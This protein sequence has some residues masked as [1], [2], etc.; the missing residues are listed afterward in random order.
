MTNAPS[1]AATAADRW[2]AWVG[3]SE[4]RRDRIT[5]APLAALAAALDR[6]DAPVAAGDALPPLAHWLYFLA[7]PRTCDLGPDGH[8]RRGGFLPPLP[9]PR[10]MWAGSRVRFHD[11]LVVGDDATCVSRI[12]GVDA[13][14]G[15]SGALVF[16]RV[17]H[18][19]STARGLA[20]ADEHDI[21]YRDAAPRDAARGG[22]TGSAAS[23][24]AP[25]EAAPADTAAASA[26]PAGSAGA[27]LRPVDHGGPA[28]ADAAASAAAAAPAPVVSP[29]P[30]F[31]RRVEPDAVLLF[32]YSALTFN[33]HRI[34]YDR[35]YAV[36]V[37]GYPGLV[38]HGPLLAT[39][40]VN[41]ARD[42]APGRRL[43]AFEFKALRPL[44]DVEPFTLHGR[45][46]GDATTALW[47]CDADGRVAVQARAEWQA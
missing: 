47:T 12:A 30:P 36:D 19:I 11:P 15:R 26:A 18:E 6:D 39:L 41:L 40:L 2:P 46:D 38:V 28:V 9:L 16:V 22:G 4:T 21:V 31:S 3:R 44:F 13:K 32:R 27:D 24:R 29:P 8:A 17:R 20:I 7:T 23:D 14:R 33:G 5:V 25:R 1:P 35:R 34:H 45:P 37:E 42:H 10:R 43:A